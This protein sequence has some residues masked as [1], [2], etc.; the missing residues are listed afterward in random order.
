MPLEMEDEK[1]LVKL[2]FPKATLK[3]IATRQKLQKETRI[4]EESLQQLNVLLDELS[5]WII[6]EAEK[7]AFN[8]GKSTIKAKHINQAVE[9]YFGKRE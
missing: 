5:G 7:L 3:R 1:T 6:R 8:E 4:S 9:I 2:P